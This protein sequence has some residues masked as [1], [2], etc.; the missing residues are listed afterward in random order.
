MRLYAK[1]A[2]V[3]CQFIQQSTVI[4][5]RSVWEQQRL[6]VG[7]HIVIWCAAWNTKADLDR[8][9]IRH[10]SKSCSACSVPSIQRPSRP[11]LRVLHGERND[12]RFAVHCSLH[13]THQMVNDLHLL[14]ASP[15]RAL[16]QP[17][18][19]HST[20]STRLIHWPYRSIDEILTWLYAYNPT[21][22]RKHSVCP[23]FPIYRRTH[24]LAARRIPADRYQ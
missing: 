24:R 14:E 2:C 19:A 11:E 9:S 7:S 1:V 18:L 6:Q 8:L 15:H 10:H 22:L 23:E 5:S 3:C 4:M 17:T 16:V 20:T 21:S 12:S 13:H